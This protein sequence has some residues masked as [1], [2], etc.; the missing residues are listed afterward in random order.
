MKYQKQVRSSRTTDVYKSLT[1]A[2]TQILSLLNAKGDKPA[3]NKLKN[4]VNSLFTQLE[5][6]VDLATDEI[7]SSN[8]YV[9]NVA[10]GDFEDEDMD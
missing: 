2:Q 4:E 10:D 8:K 5:S 3:A 9:K 1:A 6:I 7:N